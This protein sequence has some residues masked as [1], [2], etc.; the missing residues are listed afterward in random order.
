MTRRGKLNVV[1]RGN[2]RCAIAVLILLLGSTLASAQIGLYNSEDGEALNCNNLDWSE[3][4][5]DVYVLV[6]GEWKSAR[7][8]I[9][10]DQ[11]I[12]PLDL[13]P[14]N[15][16]TINGDFNNGFT[17]NFSECTSDRRAV[18]RLSV[19]AVPL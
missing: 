3:S 8:S 1:R 5:Q 14:L 2:V 18:A 12:L 15:G 10:T 17:L 7:F 19:V 9:P 11:G 16:T 4:A 6:T 13:Q